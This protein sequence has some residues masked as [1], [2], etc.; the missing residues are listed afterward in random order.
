M[1][2]PERCPAPGDGQFAGPAT[3][4]E[5]LPRR[6]PLWC[7][8]CASSRLPVA[9]PAPARRNRPRPPRPASGAAPIQRT[10]RRS[11]RT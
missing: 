4:L 11:S 2:A 3:A 9:E 10:S 6:T 8:G 7:G 5:L 1:P